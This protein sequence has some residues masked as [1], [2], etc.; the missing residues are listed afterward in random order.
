MRT[1][2][3]AVIITL[4]FAA[5]VPAMAGRSRPHGKLPSDCKSVK[6]AAA[7]AGTPVVGGSSL[8][9]TNKPECFTAQIKLYKVAE[10]NRFGLPSWGNRKPTWAKVYKVAESETPWKC[11]GSRGLSGSENVVPEP[12]SL[13]ALATGL[14]GIVAWFRRRAK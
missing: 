13:L 12:G 9:Y 1:R 11:I 10:P 3:L 2:Y 5:S 8:L 4:I 7:P 6:W 14:V